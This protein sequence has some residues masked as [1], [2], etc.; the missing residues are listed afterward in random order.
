MPAESYEPQNGRAVYRFFEL[1]DLPNI[2]KIENTLR[3]NAEG[4]ITITPPIKPY[5]G[6]K[7]GLPFFGCNRFENFGDASLA[8]DISSNYNKSFPTPGCSIPRH[9]H[10]M[11]SFHDWKFTI[12]AK[13]PNSAREIEIFF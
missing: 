11:R 13:R 6:R 1:F 7:C 3:A 5:L 4:R 8:K 2:P 10:S 9:C 12:G